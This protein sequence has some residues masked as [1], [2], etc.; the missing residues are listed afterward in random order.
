MLWGYCFL[1][2]YFDLDYK[3]SP[4]SPSFSYSISSNFLTS[5]IFLIKCVNCFHF[6]LKDCF[7]E[8]KMGDRL[9]S[10]SMEDLPVHLILEILMSGRLAVIDLISLE[11]TSRTFRGT[12]GLFPKKFKSLVDYAA[13]QLCGLS[14]IYASL[15]CNAQ[16]ELLKRCNGNWKR[17][18]RFLMAVEQSSDMVE[19]SA[20][21]VL[22]LWKTHN[23]FINVYFVW[24]IA[25]F[26]ILELINIWMKCYLFN[27]WM[28]CFKTLLLLVMRYAC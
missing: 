4:P 6:R 15:H 28:E 2:I 25:I 11:L 21:N 16:E 9:R 24:L 23:S 27:R 17:L 26:A 14:S 12:H 1:M 8:G 10:T 3:I 18:L 5:D 20:G 13:F 22:F 19:T 7:C